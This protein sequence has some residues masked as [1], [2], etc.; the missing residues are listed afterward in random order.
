MTR[1]SFATPTSRQAGPLLALAAALVA[2]PALAAVLMQNM[3][4]ELIAQDS[5]VGGWESFAVSSARSRIS[6]QAQAMKVALAPGDHASFSRAA[7][8]SPAPNAI[9]CTF[10]VSIS[11]LGPG[12]ATSQVLRM[13]WDFGASNADESDLHTYAA[14]GLVAAPAGNGFQLR[15]RVGAE[16]SPAFSGTQAVSW[17]INNSGRAMSYSAPDGRV[18]TVADDRMD[19][20]VGRDR[21]FDD[22]L[23]ANPAGRITDLKWYWSRGSGVTTFDHFAIRTLEE[24]L[25]APDGAVAE[26]DAADTDPELVSHGD[27]VALGRPMPNPFTGTMRYAYS[28]QGLP[29]SVDIAV[30][31]V[32]G[33]RVRILAH[34]TQT[35]GEY[36][37]TWDGLGDD[38]G[39]VRY[40][41]Y[42]LRARVGDERHVSRVMY[43]E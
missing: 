29:A 22:I 2:T 36:E 8:L 43:L 42:F 35:T 33:R 18:E 37:A 7:D 17:M 10:N 27:G 4:D 20:W 19:V 21:V 16:N 25:A 38:G 15:N 14:L 34:G 3:S 23:A 31:D 39:H 28:I 12:E 30:F 1:S 32:A 6:D 26:S 24:A 9:L 13:G 11:D 5:A 40:G 41:M